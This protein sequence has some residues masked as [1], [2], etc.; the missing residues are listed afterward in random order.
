MTDAQ[1]QPITLLN[2]QQVAIKAVFVDLED[3]IKALSKDQNAASVAIQHLETA[4]L[5]AFL[6][7]RDT[8]D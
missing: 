8:G 1:V 4:Q 5:W 7:A 2:P 6:A 3:A